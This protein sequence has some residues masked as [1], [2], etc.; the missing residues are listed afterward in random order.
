M[1]CDLN[2]NF[3]YLLSKKKFKDS[4]VDSESSDLSDSDEYDI[5]SYI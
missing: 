3:K 5:D 1:A 2:V 4:D